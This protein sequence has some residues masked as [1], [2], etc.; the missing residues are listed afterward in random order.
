MTRDKGT[1]SW[2]KCFPE[3]KGKEKGG[4]EF[5][6]SRSKPRFLRDGCTS[7]GGGVYARLH[8]SPE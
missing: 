5:D 6:V 3:S 7:V 1:S 8:T 4:E 2:A